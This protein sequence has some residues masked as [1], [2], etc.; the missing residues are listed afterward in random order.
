MIWYKNTVVQV[1]EVFDDARANIQYALIKL[2]EGSDDVQVYSSRI[3]VTYDEEVITIKNKLLYLFT[4]P[5]KIIIEEDDNDYW[6]T[7]SARTLIPSDRVPV[8]HALANS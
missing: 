7:C 1:E 2:F 4:Y 3:E 5:Y 8:Q 6:G